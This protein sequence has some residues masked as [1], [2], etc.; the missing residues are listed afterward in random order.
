MKLPWL[1]S[2]KRGRLEDELDEELR[3]HL[4]MAEED[5]VSGGESPESAAANARREFGNDALVREDTR[6]TWGGV[7][8]EQLA[9]DVRFGLRMLRR[10]PGFAMLATLCLT[11]GIGANAAV[12]GWIEGILLRPYPSVAHPERLFALAGTT[13]DSPDFDAISW[14][15]FVDLRRT[16]TLYE[17]IAEKITG[18]TLS[19]GDRAERVP[20]SVVS[21]NYFDAWASSLFWGAD[22]SR[23][24]RRAATPTP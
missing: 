19:I 16:G 10:E 2:R 15:D 12:Y 13:R 17:P 3:A 1:S 11:I 8:I 24:K 18:T 22:S 7:R 14:P 9:Q 20:G 23:P 6:E 4:R 21:A 5:R